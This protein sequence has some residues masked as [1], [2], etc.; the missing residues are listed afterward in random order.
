MSTMPATERRTPRGQPLRL[1]DKGPRGLKEALAAFA[2]AETVTGKE[3]LVVE[4]N[5]IYRDHILLPS[6]RASGFRTI[7]KARSAAGAARELR[8]HP[9]TAIVVTDAVLHK[10]EDGLAVCWMAKAA[11][12]PVV[13]LTDTKLPASE[14]LWLADRVVRKD[15]ISVLATVQEVL[16]AATVA[17]T[18]A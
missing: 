1:L 6:L 7:H 11:S 10:G 18:P 5:A 8:K 17:R 16:N 9:E 13:L 3:V 15:A 14:T 12:I 4:S 2:S